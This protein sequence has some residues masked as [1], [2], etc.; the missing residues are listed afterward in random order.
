MQN[1]ESGRKFNQAMASTGR[2]LATTSK[3]VGET[4]KIFFFVFNY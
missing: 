1:S 2:T 3:A 4:H